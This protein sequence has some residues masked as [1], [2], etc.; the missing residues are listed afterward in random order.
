[1]TQ[2]LKRFLFDQDFSG[3]PTRDGTRA[4]LNEAQLSPEA[5]AAMEA[6]FEEGRA[7]GLA[8]A[9]ASIEAQS[10]ASLAAIATTMRAVSYSLDRELKR[11]ET[12]SIQMA[13]TLAK[14]YADVLIDRDPAPLIAEAMRKCSEM[15]DNEAAL[16]ITIGASAPPSVREAI[17]KAAS[18][19]GFAGPISIREDEELVPGDVRITWPEGGYMR[20][21]AK[22]DAII[23]SMIEID[24]PPSALKTGTKA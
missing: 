14:L 10:T 7:L 17:S 23:R 3:R 22:I 11:I 16:V 24:I 21:R 12:D 1:M 8:E 5:L 19:V 15:T 18:E 4:S 9:Q 2:G 20:E 6:R 13:V